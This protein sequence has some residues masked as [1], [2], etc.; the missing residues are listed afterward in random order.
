MNRKEFISQLY[1][2]LS[3]I[4]RDEQNKAINYY[5]ELFDDALE[6]GRSEQDVINEVGLPKQVAENVIRELNAE[7]P[8]DPTYNAGSKTVNNQGVQYNSYN[9]NYTAKPAKNPGNGTGAK[10]A[11][12]VVLSIVLFPVLLGLAITL[13]T[14]V[15]VFGGLF[16]GFTIGGAAMVAGSIVAGIAVGSLIYF[17]A[18]LGSGILLFGLGV[19]FFF[20]VYYVIKLCSLSFKGL[21]RLFDKMFYGSKKN[22]KAV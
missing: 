17:L 11:V 5:E 9:Y 4:T 21:S 10:V 14:L 16:I 6:N 22:E 7:K 8:G 19:L 18:I 20:V 13:I 2:E 3:G 12:I 15:A 1:R